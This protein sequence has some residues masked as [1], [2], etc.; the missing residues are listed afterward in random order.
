MTVKKPVAVK[1]PKTVSTGAGAHKAK[2]RK[3]RESHAEVLKRHD[4]A[5]K[6]AKTRS[7]DK[8]LHRG[9]TPDG[10]V[11]ICSA[12]AVAEA[13]R[14]ATGRVLD[15]A[16]VLALY[17]ATASDPDEGQTLT[18]ALGAAQGLLGDLAAWPC[19]EGAGLAQV[20]APDAVNLIQRV[21]AR[22]G[23]A[24]A[25]E[26]QRPPRR[27]GE[28][29]PFIGPRDDERVLFAWECWP[30]AEMAAPLVDEEDDGR[31]VA[32]VVHRVVAEGDLTRRLDR[33]ARTG[34]LTCENARKLFEVEASHKRSVALVLGLDLPWGEPHAVT[35][36]PA[37]GTWWSWGQPMS[38]ADFPGAVIEEAWAVTWT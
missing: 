33:D 24:D 35:Y 12:R 23:E 36:N 7:R 8:R 26:S 25:H 9:W 2:E 3:T 30:K 10:D 31:W 4:A 38:P 5:V 22:F 14:L 16:D 21:A 32:E 17:R 28:L 18:E 13:V 15:D 1:K 20:R 27:D 37:D 34:L 11:A 19:S 29:A 6:A